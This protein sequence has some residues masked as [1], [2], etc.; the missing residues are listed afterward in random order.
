MKFASLFKSTQPQRFSYQARH[1][2]SEAEERN[3]FF[4]RA[5]TNH[6]QE[7]ADGQ[8]KKK[9][10]FEHKFGRERQ[11]QKGFSPLMCLGLI[12]VSGVGVKYEWLHWTAVVAVLM[13]FIALRIYLK[14][15]SKNT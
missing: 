6:T 8:L 11:T 12:I 10:K 2:D 3:T 15:K 7:L 5:P 4:K 14:F 9:I 1:F 13:F